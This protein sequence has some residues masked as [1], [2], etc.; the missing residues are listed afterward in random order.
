L[1]IPLENENILCLANIVAL[2][3]N[4]DGTDILERDG[5]VVKTSF[6]PLTLKRR[7]TELW[8]KS[9]IKGRG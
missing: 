4:L 8:Q 6:T 2:Y 5:S 3:R 9:A 1:F 7:Q